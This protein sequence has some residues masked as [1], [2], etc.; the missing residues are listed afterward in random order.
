M[1]EKKQFWK[2]MVAF[3]S[4]VTVMLVSVPTSQ[5]IISFAEET[6]AEESVIDT[7]SST[8]EST[9]TDNSYGQEDLS[10]EQG[11]ETADEELA[12][13]VTIKGTLIDQDKTLLGDT[14]MKVTVNGNVDEPQEITT[15]NDGTYE[16]ANIQKSESYTIEITNVEGYADKTFDVISDDIEINDVELQIDKYCYINFNIENYTFC[17]FYT[18]NENNEKVKIDTTKRIPVEYGTSYQFGVDTDENLDN[19]ILAKSTKEEITIPKSAEN[20]EYF[21]LSSVEDDFDII[22]DTE[23]PDLSYLVEPEDWSKSKN[24]NFSSFEEDDSIYCYFTTEAKTFKS[25]EVKENGVDITDNVKNYG[26]KYTVDENGS[27]FLCASDKHENLSEKPIC[28]TISNIDNTKPEISVDSIVTVNGNSTITASATDDQSGIDKVFLSEDGE[29]E[30]KSLDGNNDGKYIFNKISADELSKLSVV[31]VDKAENSSDVVWLNDVF[32][33][34]I[35][36]DTSNKWLKGRTI[37]VDTNSSCMIKVD[38]TE[39]TNGEFLAKSNKTY[40]IS[41][42]DSNGKVLADTTVSINNIDTDDPIISEVLKDPS[43]DWTNQSVTISG[44]AYD[45]SGIS[46]IQ[47]AKVPVE[48]KLTDDTKFYDEDVNL[49]LN[50]DGSFTFTIF[51][52]NKEEFNGTYY[53]RAVDNCSEPKKSEPVGI[54]IRIDKTP[55]N[56]EKVCYEK[57]DKSWISKIVNTLGFDLFF[58]DEMHIS[59]EA[60]DK[61]ENM[62]SGIAKYQ[63]QLVENDSDLSD[64]KWND[65]NNDKSPVEITISASDYQ[66][67]F[68]GKV[69]VRVWD[70]AGNC[71]RAVT[72]TETGEGSVVVL[73]N[74][75]PGEPDISAKTGESDYDST[76]TKN[77]VVLKPYYKEGNDGKPLSGVDHYEYAIDYADP[78]IVDTYRNDGKEEWIVIPEG[79]GITISKDTNATYYFRAISNT[80]VV[81]K[82]SSIH[83]QIQ[84]TSPENAKITLPDINGENGWYVKSFP[85]IQ[86]GMP[87]VGEYSAPVT[88]YYKLWN[89]QK[90]E[91]EPDE[92]IAFGKVSSEQTEIYNQPEIKED[93]IYQLLVWTVDDADNQCVDENLSP[94]EES[95]IL[96]VDTTAPVKQELYI[97]DQSVESGKQDISLKEENTIVYRHIYKTAIEIRTTFDFDISGKDLIQYQFVNSYAISN[98][99]WENYNEETGI[100][101]PPNKKF[102]LAVRAIDKAGNGSK[103]I[104]YSNGIIVDDKAPVGEGTA[105]EITITPDSPNVNGYH[106]GDVGV[107]ISVIDPPYDE[108]KYSQDG[109]Y[110]GLDSVVYRVIT[111]GAVTQEETLFSSVKD[112]SDADLQSTFSKN[113]T[114]SSTLNNS[115]NIIVEVVAIDRAGNERISKTADGAIQIDTTAP[116]IRISYDNNSPDATNV[117]YF[118]DARTAT[119]E[120][121]ER[122]FNP[123]D[124]RLT[125]TNTDGTIPTISGWSTYGGSGNGDDT[126]HT[127]TLTYSADGDYTF[128]IA[129]TDMADNPCTEINYVSGTAAPQEFT[130]DR[131]APVINISYDNNNVKNNKYFSKARVAT[132]VI[133]EHNFDSSRVKITATASKNGKGITIPSSNIS[134]SGSGDNHTATINYKEDGD[135]T[136]DIQFTDMAGNESGAA[137]YGS[138]AAGKDFV[139]DT[140]IE[141]PHV[142]ING[143]DGNGK[144]FKDALEL[145]ISFGDINYESYEVKL[146]R[147]RKN[148]KNIDVTEEFIK[149]LRVN[150]SSGEGIFNTFKKIQENDGIYMLTVTLTDKAGNIE[151][152]EVRFTVNRFGSV[153]EYNDYL[154]DLIADGGQYVK[155]LDDDLIITEY[156]ADKLVEDSLSIV[157]TKDGKPLEDAECEVTPVINDKVSIG[158]SGWYQYDYII[159]KDNFASDGVYKMVASSKDEAGNTPENT[160][161]ENQSILFRVD[162]TAPELTSV[163]GL[164]KSIF[165]GQKLTVGYDAYDTIGLK[166]VKVYVD[167]NEVDQVTDFTEDANNFN[168][169]FDINESKK[170]QSVRLVVEDM[171]GNITDTDSDDFTSAYSFEKAVTVS[172]NMFVRW[173]ANKPLFWCSIGG[174]CVV[175]IGAGLLVFFG[176]KKKKSA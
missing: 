113:I 81:G 88:T 30:Y 6:T 55:P 11:E 99:A 38:G 146:L 45:M 75:M 36:Y 23:A 95:R 57:E 21:L 98:N 115:N 32:T 125:L 112:P 151:T 2:R 10:G 84:K 110:S 96:K 137:N 18:L 69:Y 90:G 24:I 157:I 128:D 114:V 68:S 173:Y 156:N 17:T 131:T 26:N 119:I 129:Y 28:I 61:R 107:E 48:E 43:S 20:E 37:Q 16:I 60:N 67:G 41:A 101:V 165:N 82:V 144:A 87:E 124:V 138:S 47:Y 134:W 136:F 148:E 58:K 86:I 63:Y 164:D 83:V 104:I 105:P 27:Y 103:D 56:V 147:T 150:G 1:K 72:D 53:I 130:I 170:A 106:N 145:A 100:I 52:S 49:N 78:A 135:Y 93:G 174:I 91:A 13:T 121:T 22:I 141:K 163:T 25:S 4:S 140:T 126:V 89:K 33:M 92:G 80:E 64:D 39:I 142:T 139:V 172:T 44:K 62:D 40:K 171:A 117:K 12:Q 162:S 143:K 35:T 29:S 59:I 77:D 66:E 7:S 15:N 159:S 155:N 74:K 154:M 109:I 3:A 42:I 153:Y 31:A 34:T 166:S 122:N 14:T 65:Y 9:S 175:G 46:M 102:I 50:E 168:G 123:D 160:N 76:W 167:G 120:V 127:A 161:Y 94:T 5:V 79:K 51:I 133:Q 118:K 8:D 111:D 85:E 132:V 176:K 108:D 152:T 71:T 116:T 169:S 54:D 19:K 149:D 70:R 97:V 73:D 158:E